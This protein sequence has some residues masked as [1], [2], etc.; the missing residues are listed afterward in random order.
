MPRT[1]TASDR[2]ALIRLASSLP[3]GSVERKAILSGLSK[4]AKMVLHRAWRD[5]YNKL[6]AA[7][8]Q[9]YIALVAKVGKVFASGD[10]KLD[11]QR[12]YI[13]QYNEGSSDGARLE[14]ML[15]FE[16]L[17]NEARGERETEDWLES[18]LDYSYGLK[19]KGYGKWELDITE[20]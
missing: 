1:L 9:A 14:G 13:S 3:V 2:S 18:N 6:R 17:R 11:L 10:W 20:S 15:Y 19:N 5:T 16:D 12:S 4:Q 8:L 7:R